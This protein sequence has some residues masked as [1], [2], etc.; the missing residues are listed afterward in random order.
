MNLIGKE[1][2][3]VWTQENGNKKKLALANKWQRGFWKDYR[4]I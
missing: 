1:S 3:E 4:K 2:T